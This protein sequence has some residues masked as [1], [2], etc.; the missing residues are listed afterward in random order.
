MFTRRTCIK[1][2]AMS[3]VFLSL[4]AGSSLASALFTPKRKENPRRPDNRFIEGTHAEHGS[5]RALIGVSNGKSAYDMVKE[6]VFL[7]GGFDKLGLKGKTALVKPNVVSGERNPATTNPDVVS[8]AVKLLYENGASKVYVGDMSALFTLST[9]RNMKKNGI[10]RAAKD[11]GAEV[12]VFEDYDWVEVP[13]PRAKYV[14]S[15]YV[16]EWL[17]KADI[18]VNLPVIKTHR[19]ASYSITLKNFIGCTHLKQRPYIVDESHWEELVSEFNLAYA[20]DLNIVDGTVSMVEGGPWSG[21]PKDT[22][23]IM[24][25][26]DRVGADIVGLGVIKS[27]GLWPMVSEIEVWEQKQIKRAIETGVGRGREGLKLVTGQ[28]DKEF[29]ELMRKVRSVTGL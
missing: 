7:I 11:S 17:Y 25:S 2:A 28:G 22:N 27:F 10:Y 13:L 3:S 5:G 4:G 1:L 12:V 6:A 18:V 21:T 26:G 29:I 14:K 20:P 15:A 9:A 19:S 8:A 24:A 23:L 16:T